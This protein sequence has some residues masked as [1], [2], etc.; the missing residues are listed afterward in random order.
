MAQLYPRKQGMLVGFVFLA[1]RWDGAVNVLAALS[2]R[3]NLPLELGMFLQLSSEAFTLCYCD[4]F[5]QC[6]VLFVYALNKIPFPECPDS[7]FVAKGI[8]LEASFKLIYFHF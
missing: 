4:D 1:S 5:P 6:L 7:V 2:F 3:Q 8:L